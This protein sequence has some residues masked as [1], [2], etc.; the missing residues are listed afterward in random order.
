LSRVERRTD[1]CKLLE[2]DD[3]KCP[4]VDSI[5]AFFGSRLMSV[6]EAGFE[7]FMRLVN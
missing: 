3:S 5:L 6:S 4:V 1:D 2:I 7:R